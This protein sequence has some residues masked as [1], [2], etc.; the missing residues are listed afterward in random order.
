MSQFIN[1]RVKIKLLRG[2]KLQNNP[3][4]SNVSDNQE[5]TQ[6]KWILISVVHTNMFFFLSVTGEWSFS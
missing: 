1:D 4:W 5:V 3:S 2:V 6:N